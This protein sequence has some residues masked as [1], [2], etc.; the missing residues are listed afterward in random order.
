MRPLPASVA[1][2][3]TLVVLSTAQSSGKLRD[4]VVAQCAAQTGVN[5]IAGTRS[6]VLQLSFGVLNVLAKC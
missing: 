6:Y 4:R 1:L 2:L 5:Y 3:S